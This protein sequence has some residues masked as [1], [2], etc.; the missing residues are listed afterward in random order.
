M[1]IFLVPLLLFY[2]LGAQTTTNPDISI[3]GDIQVVHEDT[4]YF[5][6][7]GIEL[8]LQGY[9]NPFA[10]ASVY[11]HYHS[12]EGIELE[13]AYLAIERGL[14]LGL[15]LRAGVLRPLLGKI[16]AEHAHTF[17][18]IE[19]PLSVQMTLG[20]EH[21]WSNGLEINALLPLTWYS[22]VAL[23]YGS[24]PISSLTSDQ[25]SGEITSAS[26]F[27]WSNFFDLTPVTHLQVGMSY[28]QTPR[29]QN[30]L[31]GFDVKLKR[32]PDKYRSLTWQTEWFQFS[33]DQ[34]ARY[35]TGYSWLN[36]QFNKRWNLGFIL[37][38]YDGAGETR[39]SGWGIFTGFS[40]VEESS[41]LR[42]KLEQPADGK[43]LVV[44]M[45]LI[46][47]LGPHKPHRF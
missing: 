40:P 13:E 46:W 1:R 35:R 43:Q 38:A 34:I 36:I 21:W 18:F 14:P 20:P 47:S 27:T 17:P 29:R 11:F 37:D 22:S 28:Y 25:Q 31:V 9:V 45:Q 2:I 5:S 12:S 7:S 3:I 23:F 42:V 44:K 39:Q 26:C 16:N 4:T 41:V 10:K 19:T 30:Q 6:D 15:G 32:R 24:D 33:Q 8:A